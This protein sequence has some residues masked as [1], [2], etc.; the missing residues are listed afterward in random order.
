MHF[1][2]IRKRS[3]W[4]LI[5]L[6][7]LSSISSWAQSGTTPKAV[8]WPLGHFIRPAG[9]N[10]IIS[11]DSNSRFFC[12][13]RMRQVD[14]ESNDTFNPAAIAKDG[15]L[16][17]LYRAEDRSGKEIG[18]RTSRFGLAASKNGLS[19][20]KRKTPVLYPAQDAQKEME[21]PGGCED[22]RVAVT[23]DG[24][25]VMLYTQWN[26]QVP[27]LAVATSKDLVNWTKHGP[28]FKNAHGGRFFNTPSKSASIITTLKNEKLVIAQIQGK[29][30]LYW[31]ELQVSMATSTDLINWEPVLDEKGKLKKVIAPRDGYFDSELTECGPPALLTSKGILLLYNGKNKAGKKGDARYPANTYCAGRVLMDIHDPFKVIAWADKPFLVPSEPFEKSGQYPAGTVFIEG[32]VYFQKKWFLYYGCADSRVAVAVYD[33]QEKMKSK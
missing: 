10:P 8:D 4:R 9:I 16:Y 23:E 5:C 18:H 13:M 26:R 27:R 28:A 11:P 14:W 1:P 2:A 12:P 15:M 21:W 7:L 30:Q 29:Y 33:P 32:L 6:L 17:V 19:F 22:P 20:A 31:G 3:H 25:Y 24:T